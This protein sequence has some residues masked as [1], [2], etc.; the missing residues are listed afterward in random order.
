M[1]MEQI[2]ACYLFIIII[3]NAA[4]QNDDRIVAYDPLAQAGLVGTSMLKNI[5]HAKIDRMGNHFISRSRGLFSR[6]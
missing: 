5:V 6:L 1:K 4:T 3:G 2:L